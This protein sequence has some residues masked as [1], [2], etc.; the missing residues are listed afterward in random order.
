M[1]ALMNGKPVLSMGGKQLL[2]IV[3]IVWPFV[4]AA[5]WA[6]VGTDLL[7]DRRVDDKVC[8]GFVGRIGGICVVID[9]CKWA[10]TVAEYESS[11]KV[12]FK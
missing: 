11:M 4:D 5:G 10:N 1:I 8:W 6:M 12:V 3:A 7:V 9:E 2:C